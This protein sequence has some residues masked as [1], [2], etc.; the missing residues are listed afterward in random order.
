MGALTIA[1]AAGIG[2]LLAAVPGAEVVLKLAGSIYLLYIAYLVLQGGSVT[3]KEVASP[4]TV[5]QGIWFQFLNPKAW[6]FTVAAVATF[7]P[8]GLPRVLAIALADRCVDGRRGRVVVHLGGRRCRARPR[9]WMT[10][11]RGEV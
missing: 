8:E 4:L 2:A 7:L 3:R 9:S 5:W 6:V 10:S 1:I 11:D